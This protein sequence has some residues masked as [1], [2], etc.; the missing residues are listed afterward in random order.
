MKIAFFDAKPYDKPSFDRYAS[1]KDTFSKLLKDNRNQDLP[2]ALIVHNDVL[3][4]KEADFLPDF[5]EGEAS[6]P[7]KMERQLS[8]HSS[9][10]YTPGPAISLFT[11]SC[12]FPQKEQQSSCSS[13]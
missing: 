10:I 9:Q 6:P 3:A 4:L 8:I 2:T 13:V 7:S 5:L 11:S 1:E 12:D